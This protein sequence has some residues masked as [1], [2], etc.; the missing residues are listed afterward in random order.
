MS[1]RQVVLAPNSA[2][3]PL[4]EAALFYAARG[5]RVLPLEPYGKAPLGRLVPHGAS[6]ASSDPAQIIAWWTDTPA[7]NIGGHVGDDMVVID[8]DTKPA[9]N[10]RPAK[11]GDRTWAA[12]CQGHEPIHTLTAQ[13]AG[14]NG[15]GRYFFFTLPPGAVI[16][17]TA[18]ALG[19]DVD[20]ITGNK[21]VVVA[22]SVWKNGRAY[23]WLNDLEPIE[24]PEWLLALL[25]PLWQRNPAWNKD[26]GECTRQSSTRG[27][28]TYPASPS[29]PKTSTGAINW[30]DPLATRLLMRDGG[31]QRRM[32][33]HL[34]LDPTLVDEVD[35]SPRGFSSKFECPYPGHEE[36][37]RGRKSAQLSFYP[38]T[39]T[40]KVICHHRGKEDGIGLKGLDLAELFAWQQTGKYHHLN[41][42]ELKLWTLRLFIDMGVIDAP[43][44]ERRALP[45]DLPEDA[46]KDLRKVYCGIV[47][48]ARIWKLIG[49]YMPLTRSFLA[50]WCGVSEDRAGKCME[51]L[52]KHFYLKGGEYLRSD[53]TVGRTRDN[54]CWPECYTPN[55]EAKPWRGRGKGY[56]HRENWEWRK[57]FEE[58]RLMEAEQILAD[59]W[60]DSAEAELEMERWRFENSDDWD[61]VDFEWQRAQFE[62]SDAWEFENDMDDMSA[63]DDLDLMDDFEDEGEVSYE[64]QT[65]GPEDL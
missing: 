18:N 52:L 63:E 53:G 42:A 20:T 15:E 49:G 25:K 28:L 4:L 54:A 48:R 44:V 47:E 3:N 34:G 40:V 11:H 31:F 19:P 51:W 36:S 46:C 32:V 37:R 55:L 57:F 22:P 16:L 12:L 26:G 33:A 64:A 45:D 38:T 39:G 58:Q 62:D 24:L 61:L 14:G 65:A 13:T 50:R 7:A 29:L 9:E 43:D 60:A 35:A 23:T 10:G 17:N 56:V 8:P 5:W 6:Y 21:Y 1:T 41:A 2:A 59:R 27:G 30:A